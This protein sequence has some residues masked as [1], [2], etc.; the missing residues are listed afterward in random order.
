MNVIES[1]A[2]GLVSIWNHKLRSSLT[3]FGIVVGV[4][5]VISMFSF[6]DGISTR[7]MRDFEQIGFDKLLIQ[8]G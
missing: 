5:A 1:I 8:R 6:V 4:A 3:L 2:S 7:V